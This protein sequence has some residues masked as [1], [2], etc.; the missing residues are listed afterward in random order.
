MS[1]SAH[2]IAELVG[3][4]VLGDPDRLIMGVALPDRAGPQDL[5]FATSEESLA[6]VLDGRAGT[7]ITRRVS[8]L[9][10][11][12]TAIVV[13]DPRLAFA[14][15]AR[16]I[17]PEPLPTPGIH[18][19]AVVHATAVVGRGVHV[20]AF[21]VI[22]AETTLGD[23]VIVESGGVVGAGCTLGTRTRLHPRVVL[24]DGTQLGAGCVVQSGTVIGSPGFGVVPTL[25]G[26]VP[27]PQL[28]GVLVGDDVQI[29]ANCTIDRG[30]LGDTVIGEGTCIDNLVHIGHGVQI[31]RDCLIAGQ[32]GL[33][34]RAQLGD[35]VQIAGQVGVDQGARVGTGVR[36]G[37]RSWVVPNQHVPSGTWLGVPAAP[38]GEARRRIA[39]QR[40]LPQLV[41]RVRDLERGSQTQP[42]SA[43]RAPQPEPSWRLAQR[44][45]RRCH[46]ECPD[47]IYSGPEG[48]GR[49]LLHE[50]GSLTS[51]LLFIAE[52]PNLDDTFSGS[53]GRLTVDAETD[54]TGAFVTRMLGEA[55]QL[56]PRDVLI[57][58]SVLC[59]PAGSGG[60]Y[61]VKA[62]MRRACAE[63]LRRT[64]EE[65]DP[66][67]VIT[68]GVAA[69]EGLRA[70]EGHSF[71]LRN[72]V[73]TPHPFL[74]RILVPLYHPSMLGRASRGEALQ[75]RDWHALAALV[76][77]TRSP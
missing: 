39:A 54:P 6:Q 2:E 55:L 65:V 15:A 22:E 33:A 77:G 72:T 35:G 31:G 41:R 8:A 1:F 71:E 17:V 48:E 57:T 59:L 28:G 40:R 69:L 11:D 62:A 23:H 61:P 53:K 37:S 36:L 9:P 12:R 74:G 38:I 51:E 19:T 25:D 76:R 18:P 44:S 24:Y 46:T 32:S 63:H 3:G 42:L 5:A 68:L 30:A 64:I 7:V 75:V 60:R 14:Q 50:E 16:V 43:P 58:N 56:T 45:C 73:A 66:R 21:V 13:A 29:G 20:G 49:P 70:V 10:A 26:N 52:A 4:R 67:F 47:V 34:G 27:F